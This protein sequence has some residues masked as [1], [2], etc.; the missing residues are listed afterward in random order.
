MKHYTSTQQLRIDAFQLGAKIINDGFVPD[1]M[2]ALWRGGSFIGCCI[3]EL[4][5]YKLPNRVD[6]IAIRTS[7]YV[8]VDQAAPTVHVHNLGYLIER[9][10][11]HHNV[12]IVDDIYDTGLSIQAL[13]FSLQEK[14]GDNMPKDIRIATV[15]YKPTRNKTDKIPDYFVNVT[16]EWIVY[17]H[18]LEGLTIEEIR[19][20]YGEEIGDIVQ[21]CQLPK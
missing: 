21:N 1:Y 17:P 12:L 14:L 9:L 16:N 4:L 20:N 11:S 2:I 15:D 6:H 10:Q 5:N 19:E 3:H 18:E 8:G 13:Y 7:K